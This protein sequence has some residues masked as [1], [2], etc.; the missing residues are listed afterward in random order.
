MYGICGVVI[1]LN[2]IEYFRGSRRWLHGVIFARGVV[3]DIT[4]TS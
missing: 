3:I 4:V 1:E 2:S